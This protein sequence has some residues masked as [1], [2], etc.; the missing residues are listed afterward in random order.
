MNFVDALG[1]FL[2]LSIVVAGVIAVVRQGSNV[3]QILNS[4]GSA[5]S[6]I[7]TAAKA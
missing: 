4:F 2:V 6:G 7:I 3:A 1:T 5:T